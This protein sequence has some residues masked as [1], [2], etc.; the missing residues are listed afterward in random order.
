MVNDDFGLSMRIFGTDSF[1]ASNAKIDYENNCINCN[2]RI[3]FFENRENL[4]ISNNLDLEE[5]ESEIRKKMS[6]NYLLRVLKGN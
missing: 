2:G 5:G 1:R 3:T 4:E 6:K